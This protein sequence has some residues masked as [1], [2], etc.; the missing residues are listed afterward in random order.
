MLS[1]CRDTSS[2][3]WVEDPKKILD[4]ID[5]LFDVVKETEEL[6]RLVFALTNAERN[7]SRIMKK[8]KKIIKNSKVF[9]YL[10]L[11]TMFQFLA[12]SSMCIVGGIVLYKTNAIVNAINF[13]TM[14]PLAASGTVVSANQL[15]SL[16]AFSNLAIGLC[17]VNVAIAAVSIGV[18]I[19][20]IVQRH[21]EFKQFEDDIIKNKTKTL[22]LQ[23]KLTKQ[24]LD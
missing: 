18:S 1:L 19:V 21:E 5:P 14:N 16:T 7:G 11:N 15:N 20:S 6:A 17:V 22:N 9:K 10:P 12:G 13:A 23:E 8:D 2:K 3:R 4:C 24:L